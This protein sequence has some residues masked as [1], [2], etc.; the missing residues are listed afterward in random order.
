MSARNSKV[1]KWFG[2]EDKD[3]FKTRFVHYES[4]DEIHLPFHYLLNTLKSEKK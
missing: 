2:N 4:I 3:Q 1:H